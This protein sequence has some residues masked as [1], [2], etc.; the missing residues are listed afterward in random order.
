MNKKEIEE[1]LKNYHWMLNSIK[2]EREAL[3]QM[4]DNISAQYGIEASLPKAHGNSSDPVFQEVVRRGKRW[5]RIERYER[6]IKVIQDRIDRITDEREN[7]VLYWLLEGKSYRWIGQHM[8]LSFSHIKRIRDSIVD[9]LS[10]ETNGTNGTKET[11]FRKQK[12]AC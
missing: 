1:I 4:G 3:K 9:K 11:N 7:E 5:K 2:L 12:S 10:N 6:E 8:G